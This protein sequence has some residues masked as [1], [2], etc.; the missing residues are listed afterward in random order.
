MAPKPIKG[1]VQKFRKA[2][3]KAEFPS[4]NIIVFGSYAR[5]EARPDSDIDLCLVSPAFRR[6][7]EK[8][9]KEATFIAFGIDPRIQVIAA[10]PRELK[11][12]QLSPL[13]SQIRK[14]GIA[15]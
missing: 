1:I 7:K 8:Y 11:T 3:Q 2:L 9:R 5:D 12:N 15:A 4:C 10:D 13:Y 14:E 6:G